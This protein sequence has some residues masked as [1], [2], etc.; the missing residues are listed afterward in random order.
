MS[1]CSRATLLSFLM[2]S[3]LCVAAMPTLAENTSLVVVTEPIRIVDGGS[4]NDR[5]IAMEADSEGNIHYVFSRNFQHLYYAMRNPRGELLIDATQISNFG[6][7][8]ATH[9]DV[10]IDD[11]DRV[12]IVWANRAGQH[13]IMYTAI[14]PSLAAQNGVQSDDIT[15]TVIDDTVVSQ[16]S[17]NRDWPAISIDSRG[18]PHIVWE[19]SFD[20]LDKF[21]Q[22][23]QIYYHMFEV[24][25][26][27]HRAV[28]AIKETLITPVIGH[29]GHP[30]IAVDRANGDQIQ[31]VWDDTRGGKVEIVLPI[32]TSGSMYSEW[33]DMCTVLYGGSMS[34]GGNM[35]GIKPMLQDANITVFETLYALSGNWPGAAM[36][37]NCVKAYQTGGSGS[38]GP[39]SNHLGQNE[40]DHSGGI[41][42]LKDV[43]YAGNSVNL[44]QDGG[45]YSEFWGPGTTWACLSWRDA[46]GNTPGHPPTPK[47]HK[48]NPNATKIVIP[49]S[50]EGPYGG[51]PDQQADDKQTINEAHDSCIEAGIVPVPMYGGASTGVVSHMWDLATCPGS[52]VTT[53]PRNCNPN[54]PVRQQDA[55]GSVYEFPRGGGGNQMGKLVEA[56]IALATNNSREIYTTILDPYVKLQDPTFTYGSPA[57]STSGGK[58]TEDVGPADAA[59]GD[60]HLVV[61]NDTR[62]TLNDAYSFHPSIG[63]DSKGFSH[64]AWMDAR[65]YGFRLEHP[66]EVYYMKTKYAGKQPF[67]GIAGGMGTQNVWEVTPSA[68]SEVEGATGWDGRS[69]IFSSYLPSLIIDTRDNVHLSWVDNGNTSAIQEVVYTKL[70]ATSKHGPFM[71][72]DV[73]Y[74]GWD[75]TKIT[76]WQSAKLGS[77]L[78]KR[79]DLGWP[80]A[81]AADMG[82]GAHLAW[83]DTNRCSTET[84]NFLYTACYTHILT[85]IVEVQLPED[86]SYIHTIE[87][88][89]WTRFNLTVNNT[90]PGPTDLVADRYLL[91]LS[92]ET[93]PRNW[94]ANLYFASN[95]SRV[96]PD[97]EIFLKGGEAEQLYLEVRAPSIYQA[98][99][100]QDAPIMVT[101]I[102][103]KDSAIRGDRLTITRMDVVHGIK[104]D[105]SHVLADIE[106]GQTAV[107]SITIKNTGNVEDTFL[108]YDPETIEGIIQWNL[109]KGCAIKFPK[110]VTLDPDQTTTKNL[111][112]SIPEDLDA[113]TY[114]IYVKGWSAGEP[115]LS[116]ERGTYD[117]IELYVNVSIK[118][119]GNIVFIPS[120]TSKLVLPGKCKEYE[121]DVKKNFESDNIIFDLPGYEHQPSNLTESQIEDWKVDHWVVRFSFRD[122]PG[123]DTDGFGNEVP[124]DS[125]RYWNTELL[126][127]TPA[128]YPVYVEVCAPTNA[129][130]RFS[131]HQIIKA[132]LQGASRIADSVVLSTTVAQVYELEVEMVK[133]KSVIKGD[134][135]LPLS[136]VDSQIE[137]NSGYV[138][139]TNPGRILELPIHITNQGNGPDRWDLTLDGIVDKNGNRYNWDIVLNKSQIMF[140]D[141]NADQELVLEIEVPYDSLMGDYTLS[142]NILS[143]GAR[144][145]SVLPVQV[146]VLEYHDL[147]IC[148]RFTLKST[149][150]SEMGCDRSGVI[151]DRVESAIKETAP[152]KTVRF[153]FNITNYGNVEDL[154]TFHVHTKLA[155]GTWNSVPGLGSLET[156]N[157]RWDQRVWYRSDQFADTPLTEDKGI[158][159]IPEAIAPFASVT[160]VAVVE[161]SPSAVLADRALGFKV[162]SD[163]DDHDESPTWEGY[164]RDSNEID[165]EIRLRAPNLVVNKADPLATRADVGEIIEISVQVENNGNTRA[166]DVELVLCVGMS[167]DDIEENDEKCDE[168]NIKD[169]FTIQ[170]IMPTK[171]ETDVID[172]RMVYSVEAGSY[173]AFIIIDHD[174]II[175]ES[176][177]KD[178]IIAVG[179]ST[180]EGAT[181]L[182][183]TRATL[184]VAAET[185]AKVAMPVSVTV[186]LVVLAVIAFLVGGGRRKEAMDRVAE[187]S[188]L[189]VAGSSQDD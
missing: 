45:Y 148:P 175:V 90:T 60:Y 22:H 133:D 145:Q 94:T 86:E 168:D 109:C 142:F 64:I 102:S 182:S 91:N 71:T 26:I 80:P 141:R 144:L 155:N 54:G 159:S 30:D 170:R 5:T 55:G 41:R 117:V 126:D 84:N 15:L 42:E 50:D 65:D 14:D 4:V 124:W 177:E 138:V 62:L 18:N 88:G 179:S 160:V 147:K 48:W 11:D 53:T 119:V 34:S 93:L 77:Y 7:S 123:G 137:G 146:S 108:F 180:D 81:L 125:P 58:Y 52:S 129:S 13:A 151:D 97:T 79:P 74:D 143:Q 35:L 20:Q 104:L 96:L 106:Q 128:S 9:P 89:E 114:P 115:I 36:S 163:G 63:I 176:N 76:H 87:P 72:A 23:P 136:V 51:S 19:D 100:D 171:G 47:D 112:I 32:D 181:D 24:D 73:A 17:Q 165:V 92:E 1:G 2:L 68:I 99:K 83:T 164:Y 116:V 57:Y 157:V 149:V 184:D 120:D 43:V 105:T 3:S 21:Y 31:I 121:I 8:K 134:P 166:E 187:Q 49:I 161:V 10:S 130:A 40:A 162:M 78:S 12:H 95:H 103:V 178:N 154:A 152:G 189:M 107:F 6:Q 37:G 150:L 56:M 174:D 140:L 25:Y 110:S 44:P 28:T 33:A 70:N 183:S 185:A 139:E 111:E 118:S 188:S 186:L 169:R 38:Q 122:A 75:L 127:G 167:R 16:R 153:V 46:N 132:H 156:W 69:T 98:D 101:A 158:W 113:G 27:G 61:V 172:L 29:K 67:D 131:Y 39:R 66:Y 59:N 173:E 85:G 82:T 135:S